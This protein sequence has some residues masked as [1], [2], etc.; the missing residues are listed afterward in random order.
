MNI[1]VKQNV[2]SEV[3]QMRTKEANFKSIAKQVVKQ[4]AGSEK[5]HCY[6]LHVD[7]DV[8]VTT[9]HYMLCIPQAVFQRDFQT[10][11]KLG[12]YENFFYNMDFNKD[13]TVKNWCGTIE[14]EEYTNEA[15]SIL[16]VF[17]EHFVDKLAEDD[18][19][20]FAPA[21]LTTVNIN[22]ADKTF[23]VF[24]RQKKSLLCINKD[25]IDMLQDTPLSPIYGYSIVTLNNRNRYNPICYRTPYGEVDNKLR[26]HGFLVL[27]CAVDADSVLKHVLGME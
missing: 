22:S 27:P 11:L 1:V 2:F 13:Y 10:D 17:N 8:V 24:K 20:K 23:T 14:I 3:K 5:L 9:E 12:R 7:N 21:F 26:Y 6:V 16:S 19:D 15:T 18:T 25:Y 4:V